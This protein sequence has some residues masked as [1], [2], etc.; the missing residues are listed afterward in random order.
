MTY[1]PQ[2]SPLP[3]GRSLV[4]SSRGS[5]A[6]CGFL[7]L[8]LSVAPAPARE[9]GGALEFLGSARLGPD[10][11]FEGTRVGGLSGLAYDA[12]ED[13]YYAISDDP[14]EHG[15]ARIYRLGIDLSDGRLADGDLLIH[16]QVPLLSRR[17][18]LVE[19][20]T[21][22]AEGI[23]V[24]GSGAFWVV[25]E[26]FPERRIAP[27]LRVFSSSG[28]QLRE[29][30]LP[31]KFT[32][33]GRRGTGV[34][35]NRAFES[36]TLTPDGSAVFIATEN[37]LEQDGPVAT[38]SRGSPSRIVQIDTSSGDVEA[39]YLYW[40]E[41]VA[42]PPGRGQTF[43]INGLV[44][45]LALG[46]RRLLALERSSSA[47]AG[48]RILLYE[49]TFGGASNIR[50]WT[51]LRGDR[52]SRANPVRK[53]LLLDLD[54]LEI[55]LANLE[56]LSFGPLLPDGRRT[57]VMVSDDNFDDDEPTLFLAFALPADR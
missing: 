10:H 42:M 46:P 55:P 15:P 35:P 54:D 44:E 32:G 56:G 57:L 45:L 36:L 2:P 16:G 26:G 18:G 31:A 13:L 40:T 38:L 23:A 49:V 4:D 21:L 11:R 53:T 25:S 47:G 20:G 52:L 37:A 6:V 28:Q 1:Q 24:T 7:A 3:G 30:P 34:R 39:E 12:S 14:A 51:H 17:G 5:L 22:D 29:V 19:A 33:R 41:P 9:A 50:R 8:A 43:Q 48:R 27:W